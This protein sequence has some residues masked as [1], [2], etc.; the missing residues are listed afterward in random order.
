MSHVGIDGSALFFPPTTIVTHR[1]ALVK[2]QAQD[3]NMDSAAFCDVLS[4]IWGS[5]GFSNSVYLA[6]AICSGVL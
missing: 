5:L 1:R 4:G 3:K 6:M 2:N